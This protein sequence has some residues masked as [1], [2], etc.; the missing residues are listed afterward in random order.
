MS[1]DPLAEKYNWMTC[2]QFSSNQVVHARELE[3]LESYDDLNYDDLDF[4]GQWNVF[5]VDL[6]DSNGN[7]IH[8]P[9]FD[10]GEVVIEVSA[11]N[12]DKDIELIY[13][14][15]GYGE[16]NEDI[17]EADYD[18]D[19]DFVD[20]YD[21]DVNNK[22][23]NKYKNLISTSIAKAS[24]VTNLTEIIS[25]KQ[26][27]NKYKAGGDA[28]EALKDFKSLDKLKG[29]NKLF[30]KVGYAGLVI[31]GVQLASKVRNGSAENSDYA[32]FGINAA[33]TF[34]AISNPIGLVAVGAY[35]VFD[36]YY[37][38]KFWNATGINN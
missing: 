19:V 11:K 9:N 23:F 16:D 26:I 3:G 18:F 17:D 1:I 14:E 25:K 7:Q 36:Y 20:D 29:V 24:T 28:L 10:L 38:D 27:I 15:G 5:G 32:R 21:I 35:A 6:L 12:N 8:T 31:D 2:Y 37:G 4:S 30:Q 34:V 33:L 13:S 22:D